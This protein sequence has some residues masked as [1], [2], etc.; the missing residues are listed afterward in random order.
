MAP[1]SQSSEKKALKTAS[2]PVAPAAATLKPADKKASDK[3]R[4]IILA[5]NEGASQHSIDANYGADLVRAINDALVAKQDRGSIRLAKIT[6][7]RKGTVTA[8]S[9]PSAT[10]VQVSLRVRPGKLSVT[11][12]PSILNEKNPHRDN[13]KTSRSP[14]TP[15]TATIMDAAMT[16]ALPMARLVTA[17]TRPDSNAPDV[18]A[19]PVAP[20]ITP[21]AAATTATRTRAPM[22]IF[23]A[24]AVPLDQPAPG[25]RKTL[26]RPRI[27]DLDS[28]PEERTDNGQLLAL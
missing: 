13:R 20:D 19:A 23:A 15:P 7:N 17:A 24:S 18:P 27:S 16:E 4:S 9:Y 5:G 25:T 28:L 1:V 22:R 10:A 12:R 26:R 11:D 21:D 8:L 6:Q 14:P 2:S 3:A